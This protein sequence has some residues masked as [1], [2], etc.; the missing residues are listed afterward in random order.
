MDPGPHEGRG[1]C[2]LSARLRK[3]RCITFA[4]LLTRAPLTNAAFIELKVAFLRAVLCSRQSPGPWAPESEIW[5]LDPALAPCSFY[6]SFLS[7]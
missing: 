4:P 2:P 7:P 1:H 5:V 3:Q 6:N